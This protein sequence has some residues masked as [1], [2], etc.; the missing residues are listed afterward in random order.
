MV[1]LEIEEIDVRVYQNWIRINS[2]KH[3]NHSE[4]GKKDLKFDKSNV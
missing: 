2:E 4:I 1:V 3:T